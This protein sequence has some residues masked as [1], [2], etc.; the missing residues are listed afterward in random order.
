MA[1][2]SAGNPHARFDLRGEETWLKPSG[3]HRGAGSRNRCSLE[4]STGAP[5]LDST[6]TLALF[7]IASSGARVWL[8]ACPAPSY[9]YAPGETQFRPRPLSTA[10]IIDTVARRPELS[11][12]LPKS[13]AQAPKTR[14]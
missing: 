13:D 10:A 14:S 11:A 5:L 3:G 2:R 7:R 9:H 12:T 4:L 8:R 1:D 6:G